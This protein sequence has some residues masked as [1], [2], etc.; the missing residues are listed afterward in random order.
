MRL[1]TLTSDRIHATVCGT[2]RRSREH[3]VTVKGILKVGQTRAFP[4]YRFAGSHREIGRQFGESC[5][6][7]VHRNRNLAIARLEH[8]VGVDREAA[9]ANAMAFQPYVLRHAPF[10]DEEIQGVA[11]GAGI[12]LPEAYL[13]QVRAELAAPRLD[14]PNTE[15]PDE[16]TTFALLPEATVDGSPLIGQNADLPTF[17]RDIAIVAEIVPPDAPAVLMLLPAGQ[18]SYIGIN[19]RGLGVFGNYLTCDGWRLGFPRYLFSRLALTHETVDD[20]IAAVRSVRRASSRNLIMLDA[21]GTAA[22]LETTP[23]RDGRLDPDRGVL[24][25]SNHYL[26]ADLIGE[27]RS[28]PKHVRNSRVR[29]DRMRALLDRERGRLDVQRMQ[30]ILRD[31]A[32][33]P[34]TLSRMTGDD[35]ASD[36]STVASV[37][38]EPSAGRLW[39]AVGPPHEHAYRSYEFARVDIRPLAVGAIGAVG[40][41]A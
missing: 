15:T 8:S 4:F 1:Y 25:H 7:L 22:D 14:D 11:E 33:H 35:E 10:F 13:L 23:T 40:S 20:A 34:D 27:E 24:A 17:Y 21:R 32:G 12:S 2:I 26:A 39:A 31:R 16:C 36:V 38:A 28:S 19:D 5:A 6:D 18:I 9:L 37:I 29:L 30:T 3:N 41:M